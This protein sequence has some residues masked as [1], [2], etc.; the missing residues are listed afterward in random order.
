MSGRASLLAAAWTFT[1][2]HMKHATPSRDP[3]PHIPAR[4]KPPPE[5]RRSYV[6]RPAH[7][8]ASPFSSSR[9]SGAPVFC[10]RLG[11]RC[12][13]IT[14]PSAHPES[15]RGLPKLCIRWL[16]GLNFKKR[17]GGQLQC[18]V[19]AYRGE[20]SGSTA[21]H[22]LCT[23]VAPRNLIDIV[24]LYRLQPGSVQSTSKL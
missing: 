21:G 4:P 12:P 16:P 5:P 7:A 10:M 11:S 23:N 18:L 14:K 17:N 15:A 24:D 8:R 13:A 2:A 3:T 20:L 6:A 9:C 22:G 19:T 1:G